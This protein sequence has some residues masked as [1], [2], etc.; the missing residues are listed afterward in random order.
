MASE[1]REGI[2]YGR[3]GAPIIE[4]MVHMGYDSTW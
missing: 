3:G 4:E 2:L 1:L